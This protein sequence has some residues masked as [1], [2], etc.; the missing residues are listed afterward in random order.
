[1]DPVPADARATPLASTLVEVTA[2]S[3]SLLGRGFGPERSTALR[4][5]LMSDGSTQVVRTDGKPLGDLGEMFKARIESAR[6][7][8]QLR[9][10][11]DREA[12]TK[13]TTRRLAAPQGQVQVEPPTDAFAA[14]D[15]ALERKRKP[16]DLS[17]TR[18]VRYDPKTITDRI[19][20]MRHEQ[21]VSGKLPPAVEPS[22]NE[23]SAWD[24]RDADK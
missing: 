8:L 12:E 9:C 21:E 20:R 11:R 18:F 15:P 23:P 5:T 4:V 3:W 2:Q 1:M 14:A 17:S 6:T 24:A 16:A 22:A 13:R 10:L 19:Q 7:D